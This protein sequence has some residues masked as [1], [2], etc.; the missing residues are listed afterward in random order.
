MRT[1]FAW[2]ARYSF[3]SHANIGPGPFGQGPILFPFC[4][5]GYARTTFNVTV[6][7]VETVTDWVF[8]DELE[9]TLTAY[10]P[11][12]TQLEL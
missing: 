12:G 2:A 7:P 5:V 10:D 11:T 4:S 8:D 1:T 3:V 6:F 9:V